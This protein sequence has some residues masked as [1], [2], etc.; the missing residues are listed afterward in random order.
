MEQFLKE[1]I[2][3]LS[4]RQ[5]HYKDVMASGSARTI[6][7]YREIIGTIRGLAEAAYVAEEALKKIRSN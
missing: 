4:K 2:S 3:G 6:E 5:D 1:I 7:E